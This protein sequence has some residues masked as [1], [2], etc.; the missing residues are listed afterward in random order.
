MGPAECP[1]TL[2]SKYC[3]TLRNSTEERR[4][5][6]K[7]GWSLKSRINCKVFAVAGSTFCV[8]PPRCKWD[9]RSSRM[10]R[11]VDWQLVTDVS[12]RPVGPLTWTAWPLEDE[13]DRLSRNFG[14][15]KTTLR[16]NPEERRSQYILMWVE[17]CHMIICAKAK[18]HHPLSTSRFLVGPYACMPEHKVNKTGL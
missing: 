14:N 16:N 5:R 13:T 17:C 8:I 15:C 10:L 11:H 4:F 7:R 3:S 2:T 9:L 12:R 6:S 1:E 18:P